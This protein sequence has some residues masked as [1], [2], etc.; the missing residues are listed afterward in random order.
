MLRIIYTKSNR[1]VRE[2][3]G[4]WLSW[5]Y[6]RVSLTSCRSPG[7]HI[8]R[9]FPR[10]IYNN[11]RKYW[12]KRMGGT[13]PTGEW[14]IKFHEV[15]LTN[16]PFSHYILGKTAWWNLPDNPADV[17][18]SDKIRWTRTSFF[19][20]IMKRQS[21]WCKKRQGSG[22]GIL[23]LRD[24]SY[25]EIEWNTL[26][27]RGSITKWSQVRIMYTRELIHINMKK[28]TRVRDAKAP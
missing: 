11:K 25:K 6:T 4:T 21:R 19:R 14:S 18:S 23:F 9:G 27:P 13:G 28:V 7:C 12:R 26:H 16:G 1:L 10:G 5:Q 24:L 17:Y 15:M 8:I 3:Q 20:K 22:G 2:L